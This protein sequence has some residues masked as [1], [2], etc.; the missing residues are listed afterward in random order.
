MSTAKTATYSV[1]A[2]AIMLVVGIILLAFQAWILMLILGGLST[3]VTWIP[4]LGY[5][6]TVL[7]VLLLNFIAGIFRSTRS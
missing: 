2:I 4:A 6:Q 1:G 3:F 7:V 5:G